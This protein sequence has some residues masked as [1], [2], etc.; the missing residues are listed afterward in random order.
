MTESCLEGVWKVSGKCLEDVWM[1]TECCLMGVWMVSGA[2][3]SKSLHGVSVS[4]SFVFSLSL[5]ILD[6]VSQMFSL[7]LGLFDQNL[8]SLI[9]EA[10]GSCVESVCERSSGERFNLD[11]SIL[12]RPNLDSTEWDRSSWERLSWDG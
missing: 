1:V 8:V 7:G 3:I 10:P 4:T 9:L 11:R 6:L 12:D 5:I 2:E